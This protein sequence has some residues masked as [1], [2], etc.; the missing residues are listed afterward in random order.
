M[1]PSNPLPP[2]DYLLE[3][4]EYCPITGALKWRCHRAIHVRKGDT[5]G[6]LNPDGYISIS[7]DSK[8][9]LAH[10][11]AYAMHHRC[12]PFPLLVDHVNRVRSDNRATNL[13][14][15]DKYGN[16]ANSS[17]TPSNKK[18]VLISYPDG[19]GSLVC[20]SMTTAARI[21]NRS[22]NNIIKLI[23][24]GQPLLW[25]ARGGVRGERVSSGITVRYLTD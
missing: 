24:T 3:I 21:L 18:P 7:I 6:S 9:Y 5:A 11:I 22:N 15:V 19:R 25:P 10:R 14:V 1:S 23:K 2:I 8:A 20:D 16:R 12:D 17:W 4:L 13:R